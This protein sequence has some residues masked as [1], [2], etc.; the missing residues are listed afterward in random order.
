MDGLSAETWVGFI[1]WLSKEKVQKFICTGFDCFT[2][3]SIENHATIGVFAKSYS[4]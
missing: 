4:S 3:S 2:S 1:F